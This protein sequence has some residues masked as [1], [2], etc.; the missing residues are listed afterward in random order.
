LV[1]L[2]NIAYQEKNVNAAFLYTDECRFF[3]LSKE[4]FNAL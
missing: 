3:K 2:Y 4:T 1:L